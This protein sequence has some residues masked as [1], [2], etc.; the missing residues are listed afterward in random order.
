MRGKAFTVT[1]VV[2]D[3]LDRPADLVAR[4]FEAAAPNRLWVADITYVKTHTGWVCVA[5]IIDV[6]SR[7]VVGWQALRSSRSDLAI[8]AL[9]IAVF[10]RQRVGAD[11]SALTHHSDHGV[12]YLSV[13]TPSAS[14]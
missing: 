7:F 5:F 1:T 8:D 13:R 9:E 12:Q 11:L 14:L 4:R 3:R 10:N 6:F 2:D